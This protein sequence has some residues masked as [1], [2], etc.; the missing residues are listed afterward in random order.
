MFNVVLW[1]NEGTSDKIWGVTDYQ[2][3]TVS[4]WGRRDRELQFKLV[5][6]DVHTMLEKKRKRGYHDS[7]F[8]ELEAM[9]PGFRERFDHMLVLC[10]VSDG[11]HLM[12]Q[13]DDHGI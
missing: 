5:D 6:G 11:F 10:I 12:H 1:N 2:G 13:K 4:F 3:Q 9:G 8:E 7:S